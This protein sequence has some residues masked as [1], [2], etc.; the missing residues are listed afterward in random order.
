MVELAVEPAYA[1]APVDRLLTPACS[2]QAE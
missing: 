1:G 2:R